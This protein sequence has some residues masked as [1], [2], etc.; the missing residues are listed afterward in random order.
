MDNIKKLNKMLME[1]FEIEFTN[2]SLLEQAFTHSSYANE[3]HLPKASNNERLE[4]LGDAVLGLIISEYLFKKYP[5][6]PEGELSKMRSNI[7]RTESLA[8]F[9][10]E[11][12]F[13]KYILLG[14]GEEKGGGRSRDTTLENLF[15]AFL[16]S[17]LLDS[18]FS[19]VEKF[20]GKIIIPDI[21]RGDFEKIID[22]KT[23]LQEVLQVN[24]DVEIVYNIVNQTGPAHARVFDVDV[25]LNGQIIGHGQ[26]KSK[27]IAEQK[28][29]EDAL[30]QVSKNLG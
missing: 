20:I 26:G 28:A 30:K 29:A 24:G 6:R 1:K 3:H 22:F 17:L 9:A 14:H 10:R 25:S 5:D 4:F 27:K 19:T 15:E 2:L 23:N 13:D 21:L 7:V 12:D 16:G 8:N 11:C 18:D